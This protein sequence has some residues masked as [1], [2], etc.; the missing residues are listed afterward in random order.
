MSNTI[1]PKVFK[2]H[3]EQLEILKARGLQIEDDNDALENLRNI[4][5]YRLTGYMLTMKKDDKFYEGSS[6]NK[7]LRLYQFDEKL[8]R[9]ILQATE[10]IEITFRAKLAYE[11]ANKYGGLGYE[12]S[13]N[14]HCEEKHSKFIE[15]LDKKILESKELF[16]VHHRNH[17][18]SQL[19]IWAAVELFTMDILSKFFKNMHNKD[20]K[21]IAKKVYNL[22]HAVLSNWLQAITII[23]NTCAHYSRV[24]NKRFFSVRLFSNVKLNNKK[25]VSYIYILKKLL[26]PSEWRRFLHEFILLTDEYDDVI[27]LHHMGFVD[28]WNDIIN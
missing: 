8:R 2:T 14:F 1:T 12:L 7:A 13:E 17:Y 16:V 4:N 5:Y 10:I 28:N 27:E 6:F 22:P 20:K 25:L 11:F 3:E 18:E 26:P 21:I 15:I 23:R 19:P 9:L 24:Y